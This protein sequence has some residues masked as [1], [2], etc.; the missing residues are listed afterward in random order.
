MKHSERGT[1]LIDVLMAVVVLAITVALLTALLPT[2]HAT[3]RSAD[4]LGN[5]AFVAQ[6]VADRLRAP[7]V[8]ILEKGDERVGTTTYEWKVTQR[9][10][11][12]GVSQVR[13]TVGWKGAHEDFHTQDFLSSA[14]KR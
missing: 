7:G 11:D 6:K 14:R 9:T 2:S 3:I 1:A 5:A 13:I 4:E 8:A 10:E 12:A